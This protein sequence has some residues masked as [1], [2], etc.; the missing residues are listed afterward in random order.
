NGSG[1]D[2][3][4]GALPAPQSARRP[5]RGSTAAARRASMTHAARAVAILKAIAAANDQPSVGGTPNSNEDSA[6]ADAT[7]PTKPTMAPATARV[8]PRRTTSHT[9]S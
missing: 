3:V 2:G 6:R 4:D 8:A 1:A 7:A 5:C 9:T